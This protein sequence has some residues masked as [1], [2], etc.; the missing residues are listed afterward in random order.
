MLGMHLL[1]TVPVFLFAAAVG[2]SV[3][4]GQAQDP[5][6]RGASILADARKALG[7]DDKLAAIKTVQAK[8]TVRR[9]AGEINLEGDL[10][11]SIELPGK[12]LRKESIILGGGGQGL[13]RVEGL[14]GTEAWE[15]IKFGGGVSFGDGGDG[16]D[17]GFRGGG[18]RGGQPGGQARA[19]GAGA[20]PAADPEQAKQQMLIA[21]QTE[22]TRVLLA[23]L[24][25]TAQPVK[26]IGTAVTPQ[27]TAEV[28]EIQTADGTP[29]RIMIDSKTNMPLMLQWTGIP[30]DPLAA[31][32]GRA[33]FGRRGGRGGRGGFP[34]GGRGGFPGG[35]QPAR[36]AQP[37]AGIVRADALAQPTALQM[38]LSDYKT[39]NGVKLPH[40]MVRGA[41]DQVTEEWIIRSYRINPNIKP[42]TFSK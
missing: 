18:N 6:A 35:G 39:V 26:W 4:A 9:G 19:G 10:D 42:E 29:T 32:A 11:L 16:G 22:V 20:Q 41:G 25:T 30:Q 28:L 34:G 3:Y 31:L 15:E 38:F 14:N 36:G 1:R 21:R 27:A 7:G 5:I 33:G 24:L 23:M 12:Y 40:L 17:G 13:D 37:D 8:G 2:A